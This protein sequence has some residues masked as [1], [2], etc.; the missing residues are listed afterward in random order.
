MMKFEEYLHW[1]ASCEKSN[2]RI[3]PAQI[4]IHKNWQNIQMK[5]NFRN[6]FMKYYEFDKIRNSN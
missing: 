4:P 2:A 6:I 1:H 5:M 3:A